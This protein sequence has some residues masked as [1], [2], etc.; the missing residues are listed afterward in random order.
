MRRVKS[1]KFRVMNFIFI[2]LFALC[3]LHSAL[4]TSALA[5][6]STPSSSIKEKLQQLQSAIAS[7]AAKLKQEVDRKLKDKSYIGTIKSKTSS[8]ITITSAQ[9]AKTI[10]TNQ[11]TVYVNQLKP[12]SKITLSTL[13]AKDH[14]AALGDVD[15]TGVL[16][17]KKIVLLPTDNANS[18]T[19]LWGQVVTIS[20]KTVTIKTKDRKNIPV[21]LPKLSEV[22][23]NEYLILVGKMS[24]KEIF[25]AEFIHKLPQAGVLNLK[26]KNASQSATSSASPSAKPKTTS[27]PKTNP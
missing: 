9:G 12:K 11:D 6:E 4:V 16:I 14:I 25:E 18:K 23:L 1:S 20:E 17:A 24:D 3:T 5:D 15:E 8:S 22:K 7:K 19:F 13:I 27:K 2:F 26:L 10:N 21:T